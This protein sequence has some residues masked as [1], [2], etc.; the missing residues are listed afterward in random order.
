MGKV[1]NFLLITLLFLLA[2]GCGNTR[3][4]PN[5]NQPTFGY[6]GTMLAVYEMAVTNTQLDSICLADTLSMDFN[7]WINGFYVDYETRDT[8]FKHTFIKNTGG[9]ETIYIVTEWSD[10]LA[11]TK[12]IRK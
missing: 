10:S 5:K 2:L 6:G 8:V 12:R 1:K 3:R 9:K 4:L 11:I 7:K